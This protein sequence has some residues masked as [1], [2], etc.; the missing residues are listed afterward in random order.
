[1]RTAAVSE[2]DCHR[3]SNRRAGATFHS[4]TMIIAWTLAETW[5]GP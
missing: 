5:I 2:E 1:M 4:P 3:G